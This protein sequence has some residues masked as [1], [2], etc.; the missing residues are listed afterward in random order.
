M[1]YGRRVFLTCVGAV[2][3]LMGVLGATGQ[4]APLNLTLTSAPDIF[5]GFIDVTYT[6]SS[7]Q[8]LAQGFS[9]KYYDGTATND[10]PNGDFNITATIDGAGVVSSGSLSITGTVQNTIYSGVLLTGNVSAFGFRNTGGDPFEF[11]FNITGGSLA[12]VFGAQVGLILEAHS[13]FN[14]SFAANF[15]N[16]LGGTPGTG[17]VTSDVAPVI[18][19]PS[20]NFLVVLAGCLLLTGGFA[21]KGERR[22][23][24]AGD[25]AGAWVR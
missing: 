8:F 25:V 16:L 17:S 1:E 20:T 15:N 19:E 18:P 22:Q 14:G 23:P 3:L 11:T 9:L 5:S 12:P 13:T 21:W 10:I 24:L 7:D 2:M 6:A 4:A